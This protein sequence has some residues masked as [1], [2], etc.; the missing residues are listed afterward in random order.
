MTGDYQ[1][2]V[3]DNPCSICI[4]FCLQLLPYIDGFNHVARIAV[5]A[6]VDIAIVK[7]CIQN[8]M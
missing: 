7:A 6:D 8:L 5:D 3:N 2:P 1:F 4:V